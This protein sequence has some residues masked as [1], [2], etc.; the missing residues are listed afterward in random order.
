MY[1]FLSLIT[2]DKVLI[3][4]FLIKD[5]F[6]FFLLPSLTSCIKRDPTACALELNMKS[7]FVGDTKGGSGKLGYGLTCKVI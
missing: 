3:S 5:Y 4:L 6:T 7:F 1:F 2:N